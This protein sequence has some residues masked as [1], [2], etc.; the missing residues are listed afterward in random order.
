MKNVVTS[1]LLFFSVL[2]YLSIFVYFY[3]GYT[4]RNDDSAYVNQAILFRDGKGVIVSDPFDGYGFYYDY[5]V[6]GFYSAFPP[7]T[8]LL[9]VPFVAV[10]WRAAFI[11]NALFHIISFLF[12]IKI[13]DRFSIDRKYSLLFLFY[14]MLAF[15]STLILSETPTVLFIVIGFYFYTKKNLGRRDIIISG[16]AFGVL[17]FFRLPNVFITLAFLMSPVLRKE[18]RRFF[19]MFLSA[20]PFILLL[21]S[22]NMY[23]LGGVGS[24]IQM[25][26]I[27][28]KSAYDYLEYINF[29]LSSLLLGFAELGI[30]VGIESLIPLFFIPG[31]ILAVIFYRGEFSLE[32]CLS[33][34][35]LVFFYVVIATTH[36][37]NYMLPL[38]PLMLLPQII[39]LK[40]FFGKLGLGEK[41]IYMMVVFMI[42]FLIITLNSNNYLIEKRIVF[43]DNIR[44]AFSNGSIDIL[45]GGG[46]LGRHF[47]RDDIDVKIYRN[48]IKD[49][50][51]NQSVYDFYENTHTKT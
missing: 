44:D 40:R 4:I 31:S 42:I 9:L 51:Y 1:R 37:H 32:I 21:V 38:V 24:P 45:E 25:N 16:I 13:L 33:V 29:F 46:S 22:Y 12:F 49:G 39:F 15:F 35:L 30:S 36:H 6:G 26:D 11:M 50:R 19:L 5:D 2:I 8:S 48:D 10:H 14:P 27:G 34:A 17:P 41:P 43:V 20:I 3:P 28:F 23:F 47:L 7:G 18:Y